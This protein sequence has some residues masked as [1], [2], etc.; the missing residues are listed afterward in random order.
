MQ[1]DCV[2]GVCEV[3]AFA[4]E[5]GGGGDVGEVGEVDCGC[6]MEVFGFREDVGEVLAEGVEFWFWQGD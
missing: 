3:V 1:T 5:A 2:Q 4:E 6:G